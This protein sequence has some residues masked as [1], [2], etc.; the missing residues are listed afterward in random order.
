MCSILTTVQYILGYSIIFNKYNIHYLTNCTE[1]TTN[2]T[3]FITYQGRRELQKWMAYTSINIQLNATDIADGNKILALRKT[4]LYFTYLIVWQYIF[5]ATVNAMNAHY[6]Q[7]LK[8]VFMKL[9]I[10]CLPV[11]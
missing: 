1:T 7:C 2:A 4:H 9:A 5:A 11:F 10:Y 8:Y 6:I 3:N